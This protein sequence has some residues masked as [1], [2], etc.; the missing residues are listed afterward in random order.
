MEKQETEH[1]CPSD[2]QEWRAWL[3][4]NHVQKDSVWLIIHKKKSACP[5]LSW[6]E[7]VDHA[8]C[9]GWID[10]IKKTIDSEKYKQY[11][12]KRKAKSNW[13]RINK[14][15]VVYLTEQNLMTKAGL[16]SITIAKTNGSWSILDHIE[17]LII[18][19]DLAVALEE[20]EG[21]NAY[22][23]GLSK[24]A[25]KILLHWVVS[26]KRPE[27]REKRILEIAENAS[28]DQKPKPFR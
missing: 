3:E 18:P 10:S 1:F 4:T 11:F 20:R 6:S 9:F 7:A 13:S 12:G 5:N 15:K 14:E 23:E 19:E 26:A 22:F 25:K 27:T 21:S 17:A 2:P 16:Q 24:S 28:K 8:L